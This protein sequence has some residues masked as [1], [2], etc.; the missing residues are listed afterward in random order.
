MPFV[1]T[2]RLS[3]KGARM[4]MEAA[5]GKAESYGIAVTVAIVDAGGHMLNLERMDGGR[6]HTI[7]SS[8]TKA[9][10]SASNKRPTT[11]KGAQAQDLDTLHAVGL[12]LAAGAERWT[13][14]EGGFP[15]IY[16]GECVGGIGISGGDWEQDQ[17]IAQSAIDA[18]GAGTSID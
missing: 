17:A 11:T 14:M 1:Q 5:I 15:I 9:V 8:T 10:C 3:S 2:T 7:H 6:F 13:A 4:M 18:V 12:S 16:G